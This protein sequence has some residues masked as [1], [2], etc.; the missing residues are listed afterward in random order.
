MSWQTAAR[1][2]RILLAAT[3]APTPEP[4]IED[5]ARGLA[6]LDRQAQA[7]REVGVVVIGVGAVAP[8]IDELVPE[9]RGLEAPDELVLHGGA[10]VVGREGDAHP[11]SSLSCGRGPTPDERSTPASPGARVG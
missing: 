8:E 2:P 10:G 4:Q 3:D 11:G 9:A 6:P 5:P 7:P 1:T